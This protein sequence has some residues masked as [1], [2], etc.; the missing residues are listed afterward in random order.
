MIVSQSIRLPVPRILIKPSQRAFAGDHP[1]ALHPAPPV[2]PVV[3]IRVEPVTALGI[4]A[5]AP[6]V[7]VP[8]DVAMEQRSSPDV[9][10]KAPGDLGVV[11]QG[12]VPKVVVFGPAVH[13]QRSAGPKA[14]CQ[15]DRHP[16]RPKEVKPYCMVAWT[17]KRAKE[18]D[19]SE[20]FHPFVIWQNDK[21]GENI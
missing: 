6:F 17:N 10:T 7:V 20:E 4:C 8:F 11:V 13:G 19:D 2:I 12:R 16:V 3:V 9:G 5:T 18:Q 1:P 14:V 21:K 15:P